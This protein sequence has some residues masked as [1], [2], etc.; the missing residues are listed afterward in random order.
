MQATQP[1][2]TKIDF[3]KQP[4]RKQSGPASQKK[5]NSNRLHQKMLKKK[6]KSQPQ[7]QQA[8]ISKSERKA[9]NQFWLSLDFHSR[10][11][12][13]QIQNSHLLK[14]IKEKHKHICSCTVCGRKR[15]VL[16]R[17]IERFF[18]QYNEELE[19]RHEK[20]ISSLPM[21]LISTIRNK[22]AQQKK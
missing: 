22:V 5:K 3:C 21:Q 15:A 16:D 12:I 1:E 13:L 14:R 10:K 20:G 6:L 2:K 9:I 17:E 4:V 7:I 8:T 11:K 18:E 19:E